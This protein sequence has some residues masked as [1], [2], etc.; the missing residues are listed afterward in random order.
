MSQLLRSPLFA[1]V[2]P[3]VIAPE[4]GLEIASP[5]TKAV[6][7]EPLARLLVRRHDRLIVVRIEEVDWIESAGNYVRLHLGDDA[8]HLRQTLGGLAARLD[9]RRFVRVHRTA[10][11][12]LNSI[13][14]LS[15]GT[16]GVGALR[17]RNGR[18]LP[19][20]RRHRRRLLALVGSS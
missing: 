7:A 9:P 10:I 4:R 12:N 6:W 15:S 20:S 18:E 17:L 19:V 16:A 8:L 3:G 2:A 11:V 5:A 14:E 1:P 13:V